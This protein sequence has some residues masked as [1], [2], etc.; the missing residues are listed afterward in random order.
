[1]ANLHVTYADLENA[2]TQLQNGHQEIDEKLT[3]LR[4]YIDNLVSEGYVTDQSSVAFQEQFHQFLT[5]AD[6]C[7]GALDGMGTFLQKAAQAMQETDTGLANAIR[8]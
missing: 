3:G 7:I 1:M 6:Q 4:N 2:R 5:G 8:G